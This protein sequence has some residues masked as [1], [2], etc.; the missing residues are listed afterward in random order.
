MATRASICSDNPSNSA[1]ALVTS[2][3]PAEMS[4]VDTWAPLRASRT[5]ISPIPHPYS[6][7]RLPDRSPKNSDTPGITAEPRA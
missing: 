7:I 6:R 4:K 5:D 1:R 2:T 3:L